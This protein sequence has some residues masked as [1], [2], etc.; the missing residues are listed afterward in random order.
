MG[1]KYLN[2]FLK[3]NAS[4]GLQKISVS[5][6]SNKVIVIDT[7]IYLY[8]FIGDGNLIENIYKMCSIFYKYNIIPLFIFD[9]KPPKEKEE[10]NSKRREDKIKAEEKYNTIF[11]EYT[12]EKDES[13]KN[14]LLSKL[15][16]LKKQF[17][18]VSKNDI[19][20][21][22]QIIQ[23]F[24]MS[25]INA[26]SEA[27]TLCAYYVKFNNA[28]A[29]LSED[30]DMFIYGC[31]RIIRYFS[32]T[33]ENCILYDFEK[34]IDTLK[35]SK[36]QFYQ[37][38]IL[39]GTDYKKFDINIST[40]YKTIL[41]YNTIDKHFD[42]INYLELHNDKFSLEEFNTICKLFDIPYKEYKTMFKNILIKNTDININNL[43]N[44]LA[45]FGF[46]II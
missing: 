17:I 2:T 36:K 37:M 33:Y 12:K 15:K 35:I 26:P 1:V 27:D 11:D 6:L 13:K 45:K 29:C 3:N 39:S 44:I 16:N 22:K 30:M 7:S 28:Y 38:C 34:I 41:K 18:R 19:N 20:N 43:K 8:K 4:D 21:V 24:G 31:N 9:G 23:S 46:I 42:Y 5:E 32:L 10:E 14:E 40:S 25:Y